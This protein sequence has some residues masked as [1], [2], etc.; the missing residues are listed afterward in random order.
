MR[1]FLLKNYVYFIITYFKKKIITFLKYFILYLYFFLDLWYNG[2][3][4]TFL[5]KKYIAICY[6][7]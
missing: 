5:G 4:G 6:I 1:I 7:I 2:V 3:N